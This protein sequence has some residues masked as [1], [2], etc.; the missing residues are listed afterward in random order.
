MWVDGVVRIIQHFLLNGHLGKVIDKLPKITPRGPTWS[1]NESSLSRFMLG[2][3]SWDSTSTSMDSLSPSS[4][5]PFCQSSPDVILD[6]QKRGFRAALDHARV[7][8]LSVSTFSLLDRFLYLILT[9][10]RLSTRHR[11]LLDTLW[12]LKCCLKRKFEIN[13]P[14]LL[15]LASFNN[16]LNQGKRKINNL[17]VKIKR[18]HGNVRLCCPDLLL[19]V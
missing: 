11:T 9:F 16:L 5:T 8:R 14:G 12:A 19:L 13:L 6:V 2:R 4:F 7:F 18:C 17:G 3:S 15:K 10:T 1:F